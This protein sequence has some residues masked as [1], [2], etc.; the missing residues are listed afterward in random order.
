MCQKLKGGGKLGIFQKYY[1]PKCGSN[2]IGADDNNYL[3][4]DECEFEGFVYPT[5]ILPKETFLELCKEFD[6]SEDD[7]KKEQE[8]FERIAKILN[9]LPEG[10]P[11]VT[12]E[13]GEYW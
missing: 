13:T 12:H 10:Q 6:H 2:E 1:C 9:V 8:L 11:F 3:I 7:P 4:C 5:K